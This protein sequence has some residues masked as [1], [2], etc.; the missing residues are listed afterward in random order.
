M[1][2]LLPLLRMK[3][4]CVCLKVATKRWFVVFFLQSTVV[5]TQRGHVERSPVG[6]KLWVVLN[7]SARSFPIHTVK[8]PQRPRCLK[9][10]SPA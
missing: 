2:I 5:L 7:L 10:W 3:R 8:F 6:A 4:V 1:I 9:A